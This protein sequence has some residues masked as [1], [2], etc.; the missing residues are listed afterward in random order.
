MANQEINSRL[1]K[2]VCYNQYGGPDVLNLVE[3]PKPEPKANEVLVKVVASSVTPGAIW[4]RRGSYEGSWFFTFFIRVLFGLFSPRNKVLGF[5]FSG[6]VEAVGASIT[7]FKIGDEVY[8]STT[9]LKQGA[10]AEY[11]CV[12]QQWKQGTILRKPVGLSFQQAAVLSVGSMT[13]SNFLQKA[14]I[15]SGDKV[16]IYGGSGSVG[17]YAIQLA[18]FMGGTVDAVCSAGNADMVK[19]LGAQVAYDYKNWI[20]AE[21]NGHY[22]VVFDAVNKLPKSTAQKLLKPR[23]RYVSV[24]GMFVESD[25]LMDVVHDAIKVNRL[26]PFIDRIYSIEQIR[27][28]H[29]YAELGHKRGNVVILVDSALN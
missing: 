20:P 13:A 27:E 9:G 6:I 24:S 28:A 10:Y 19:Q 25:Q 22:D 11:I 7:K 1:M 21:L 18:A 26:T 2:A 4:V 15:K 29:R 8:G 12:P 16:L 14:G 3:I 5:E 17:S 23:G